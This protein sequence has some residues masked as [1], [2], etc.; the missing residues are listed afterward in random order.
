[1][2]PLLPAAAAVLLSLPSW[3]DT[4][5]NGKDL[6]AWETRR[7]AKGSDCWKVGLPTVKAADPKTLDVA[8]GEGAMV[9]VVT[10]HGQSWDIASRQ[11][12]G[13]KFRIELEF[14][15][16]KGSNSGIYVMGE[17]E[18]QVL[19][20]HGK[21]DKDLGPGDLGAVYSAAVPKVN[22]AK[23]PGEWQKFVIDF[24]APKFDASGNKTGNAVFLKVELNGKVLHQDLE[25]KGPTPGGLTG[26]EHAEGPLMFQ[27]NHG[28]VAYR[29]IKV[30]PLP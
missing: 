30:T 1:M 6:T 22:A 29:N 7:E 5:F 26:K 24:Q 12:W 8:A 25:I 10:A 21:P 17:Y 13:G 20:S 14:M 18:V 28:A 3:A 2:N 27:G 16:P 9:N 19:D 23:A 15:V 11:K 4:P